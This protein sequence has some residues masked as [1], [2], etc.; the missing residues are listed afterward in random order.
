M[1]KMEKSYLE[2][3]YEELAFESIEE[4]EEVVSL[5]KFGRYSYTKTT[6]ERALELELEILEMKRGELF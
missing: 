5:E 4:K 2:G 6:R 3:L 1:K